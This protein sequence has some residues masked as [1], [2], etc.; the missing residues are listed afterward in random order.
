M[1]YL[2]YITHGVQYTNSITWPCVAGGVKKFMYMYIYVEPVFCGVRRLHVG[3]CCLS[4]DPTSDQ[5]KACQ[6]C[7]PLSIANDIRHPQ[8]ARMTT[9]GT[10]LPRISISIQWKDEHGICEREDD[11][12]EYLYN[13]Y[14][15][16]ILI[17]Y[18]GYMPIPEQM[19]MLLTS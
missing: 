4:A 17:N 16:D 3:Y 1:A 5:E 9:K 11:E 8:Y 19:K 7:G 2:Y 18:A 12:V 6:R 14:T 13:I 10:G 15:P